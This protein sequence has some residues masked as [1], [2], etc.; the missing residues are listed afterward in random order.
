MYAGPV[1]KSD[2]GIGNPMKIIPTLTLLL[3][4]AAGPALADGHREKHDGHGMKPMKHG[5]HQMKGLTVKAAWARASVGKN[6]AAF[7]TIRNE[8]D[9]DDKLVSV[10][11]DVAR[12]VEIHTHIKDG[13]IMRMR[14]VSQIDL[15]KGK[16]VAM[17]PG[18]HHIMLMGLMRKLKDG[19]S[20]P[21]TLVFEKAGKIQTTVSVTKIGAMGPNGM[22]NDSHGSHGKMKH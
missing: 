10:E 4:I 5:A 18:G 19:E 14:R 8:T 12:R 7:A 15:P 22:K 1:E 16:T 11:A 20:F 2:K 13:D 3:T 17:G 6:G 21:L 9:T